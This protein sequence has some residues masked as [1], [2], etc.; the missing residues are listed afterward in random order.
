MNNYLNKTYIILDRELKGYFRTPL[1]SIFL[2]VFLA[3]S[4]GMTF[5]L[6]R[7]F[8][9]DQADLT[10]FFSWHPWLFLV[11][12][13]AIGM[14][15]WAEERRSGTIE[16]LITLPVTN[17]QLVV[18]KFLASWIFTLIALILTMPIWITVNYLGSPDNG[19]IFSGYIGSLLMAGGFIAIG[20]CI[21][22]TTQNQVIA[23]ILSVVICFLFL[24]SGTSLVLD[25]FYI[26][27]IQQYTNKQNILW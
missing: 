8:E 14:R 11:L 3:L 15:L 10:A 1:A 23:F 16:L 13:P 19:V 12:M 6:G 25:F 4:S 18:G 5:F 24:L 17:T 27:C 9:R 20:S 21:S 22:S 7:F 26:R 2:L